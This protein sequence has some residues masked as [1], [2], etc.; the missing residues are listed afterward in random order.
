MPPPPA[1]VDAQLLRDD[2]VRQE[3]KEA[4]R[5]RRRL[6]E[7]TE[8]SH[9]QAFGLQLP[10]LVT[11]DVFTERQRYTTGTDAAEKKLERHPP[12]FESVQELAEKIEQ[13][14]V[15]A[16]E[17]PV[18]P[19]KPGLR[20][21]RVLPI[22]P[23][24]VLWTNRYR[25]VVFDEVPVEPS[26]NDLLFKTTPNPRSTCFGF[27]SP[28]D[29]TELGS[30]SLMQNYVWSN[31]GE[32]TRRSA[33][34]EGQAIL[35]SFPRGGPVE[36][37]KENAAGEVRFVQAP[38]LMRLTKQKAMRLDLNLDLQALSVKHR[39]QTPAEIEEEA[40]VARQVLVDEHEEVDKS[41]ASLDY[42]DGQWVI[43]LDPRSRCR[44][45]GSRPPGPESSAPEGQ[46]SRSE[47][48]DAA[49]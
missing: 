24:A 25:Q 30:Y 28:V 34:G 20:A 44:S 15:A 26:R 9:R 3:V 43:H 32:F 46:R 11:N 40:P 8:A 45:S 49:G 42:V 37:G 29:G 17:A 36:D 14:F 31:R 27:F 39:D 33:C 22:V 19:T 23:D 6:T 47:A 7:R 5:K 18:H 41:E 35:L 13:S 10:L 1:P 12:G 2:D 48:G 16:K 38:T 4:E 21:K